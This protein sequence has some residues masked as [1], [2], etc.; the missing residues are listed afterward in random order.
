M[1]MYIK[2]TNFGLYGSQPWEL[3]EPLC[4]AKPVALPVSTPEIGG[5]KPTPSRIHESERILMAEIMT[6]IYVCS[7]RIITVV[8]SNIL[9]VSLALMNIV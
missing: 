7:A 6:N 2:I 8:Q 4:I 9:Y 3:I 5:T 1:I